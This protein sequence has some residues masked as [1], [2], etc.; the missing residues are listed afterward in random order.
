MKREKKSLNNNKINQERL[1]EEIAE[2]LSRIG[3]DA[4]EK[5]SWV[6]RLLNV[7]A[8]LALML[9]KRAAEWNDCKC[10]SWS[11]ADFVKKSDCRLIK[12]EYLSGYG[13]VGNYSIL[14]Y[15]E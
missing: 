4:R 2:C 9:D 15:W 13:D 6:K 10:L 14:Y 12:E 7:W 3:A 11:G 8:E 5:S 1:S